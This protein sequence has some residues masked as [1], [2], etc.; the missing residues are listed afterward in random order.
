MSQWIEREIEYVPERWHD[1]AYLLERLETGEIY[2]KD[3]GKYYVSMQESQYGTRGPQK[4]QKWGLCVVCNRSEPLTK[5]TKYKG[6]LYCK[7]HIDDAVI[8]GEK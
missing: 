6:K 4:F 7:R 3:N 2:L 5:L 1:D 8:E